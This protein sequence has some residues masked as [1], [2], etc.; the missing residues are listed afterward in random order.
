MN[1]LLLDPLLLLS[2]SAR[3]PGFVNSMTCLSTVYPPSIYRTVR[4]A[5]ATGPSPQKSGSL[6]VYVLVDVD[7]RILLR[8]GPILE[9]PVANTEGHRERRTKRHTRNRRSRNRGSRN[10]R[11]RNRKSKNR[12]SRNRRGGN[13]LTGADELGSDVASGSGLL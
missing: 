6:V 5:M 12:R 8:P 4:I 7:G 13:H 10:R 11:S 9:V 1:S 2:G 3:L